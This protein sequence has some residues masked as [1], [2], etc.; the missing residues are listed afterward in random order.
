MKDKKA[1]TAPCGLDCFNCE[2][3]E[4]NLTSDFAEFIHSKSGF[5]KKISPA[6][7]A[8]LRMANTIIS[9]QMGAPL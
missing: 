8:G 1:L 3:H 9:H 4:D 5:Q 7:D 6:K 2:L